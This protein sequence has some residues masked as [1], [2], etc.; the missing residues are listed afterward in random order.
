MKSHWR[1]S[2]YAAYVFFTLTSFP[3]SP[4]PPL[5]LPFLLPLIRTHLLIREKLL[6]CVALRVWFPE[7]RCWSPSSGTFYLCDLGHL[8]LSL[9]ICNRIL[10]SQVVVRTKLDSGDFVSKRMLSLTAPSSS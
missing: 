2:Y 6:G 10:T 3:S 9:L 5:R 4:S 8:N 7:D 1:V